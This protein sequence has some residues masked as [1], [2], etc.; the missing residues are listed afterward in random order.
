MAFDPA[1]FR[2]NFPAFANVTAY[3]DSTLIAYW[4]I[5]TLYIPE[6]DYGD[7]IGAARVR[8]IELM[9]AHLLVLNDRIVAGDT[10]LQ[11]TS[12]TEDKV[13]VTVATLPER[14]FLQAWLNLTGY[15][16]QLRGLLKIKSAGGWSVGGFPELAAF[17]R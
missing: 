6:P 12:S 11:V 13:S 1:Q 15:G 14:S 8:C 5:A 9:E 4:G 7:L 16:Q 10:T 17:R 2:V 3:P